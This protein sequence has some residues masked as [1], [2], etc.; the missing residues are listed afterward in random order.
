[1]TASDTIMEE[2]CQ[3]GREARASAAAPAEQP[4]QLPHKHGHVKQHT[5]GA[6]RMT[7][8]R[9]LGR[10]RRAFMAGSLP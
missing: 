7:L 1:M 8:K 3:R 10:A 5:H 9:V 6:A 2:M 4:D